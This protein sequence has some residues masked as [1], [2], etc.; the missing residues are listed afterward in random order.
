MTNF[1]GFKYLC[2]NRQQ[3]HLVEDLQQMLFDTLCDTL[4]TAHAAPADRLIL[5]ALAS[6]LI[7]TYV[8]WFSHD[9][10]ITYDALTETNQQ[11]V[12]TQVA[13]LT[14]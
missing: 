13:L 1:E 11:L 14:K 8:Y 7:N 9:D 4:L 12:K 6:G 10:Q 3:H 2:L 5:S